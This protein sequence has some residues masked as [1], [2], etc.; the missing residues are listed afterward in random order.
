MISPT[1]LSPAVNSPSQDGTRL[2]DL[3]SDTVTLPTAEMYERMRHAALGDDGLDGDPTAR[4]LEALAARTF[5]KEAGLY[6]PTATMGNLLAVLTQVARQGQV[7]M[8]ASAHMYLTERGGATLGGIAYHG[9]AGTAGEMDLGALKNALQSSSPLRTELVC[10]E[11]THVNAGGAVLSLAHMRA[12]H[13]MAHGAGARVHLDGARIFNAAV[14]LQ[15]AP[16]AVACFADTVSICL[17]KGLSAPAGAVLVGPAET[18]S[19]ARQLRKVLGGTQ[20]QIGILAASGLEAIEAM[21][22]RLAQDHVMAQQLGRG[23]RAVLPDH[24]GLTGPVTNII[25]VELPEGVPD[26]SAWA[27][28]AQKHG[29]LIRPWGLRR[30]RLVTHRHIDSAGV[31]AAITGFEKAATELIG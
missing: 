11:T 2:T 12:V 29:V 21:P 4:E 28:E 23:L 20:R 22:Q 14:A 30:I 17:S 18:L 10:M 3:R 5:G 26:S 25:F 8:E 7:V 6:V 24:I 31:A 13:D 1:S 16:D 27:R 9:I 19:R 15:V